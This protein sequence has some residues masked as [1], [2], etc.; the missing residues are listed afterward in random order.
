MNRFK[1]I[2]F[3]CRDNSCR[4]PMA[5][6]IMKSR[7]RHKDIEII[8]RGVTVLFS[9]PYNPKAAA[10]LRGRGMI[11]D[12]RTTVQ[13]SEED[14][15][16]SSGEVLVLALGILEKERLMETFDPSNLYTV[17]EFAG[18]VGEISDP[19]GKEIEAYVTF[20]AELEALIDKVDAKLSLFETEDIV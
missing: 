8:S 10:V 18:E 2:I 1:K 5:E 6:L 4:S 20:E 17:S 11:L 3:V 15:S 9:E 13:I 7:T 19:Y 12:N 14:L 16:E